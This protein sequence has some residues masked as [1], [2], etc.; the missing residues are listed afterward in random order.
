MIIIFTNHA[1]KRMKE[2]RISR[3][4]V[5]ITVRH[6]DVIEEN[7]GIQIFRKRYK[8]SSLEVVTEVKKGKLIVITLYWQ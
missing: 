1:R 6:P 7:N 5:A 3:A 4:E 2:R 8:L